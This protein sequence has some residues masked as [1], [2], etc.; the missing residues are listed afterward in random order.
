MAPLLMGLSALGLIILITG[1]AMA[2]RRKEGKP[3]LPAAFG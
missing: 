2:T 1:I 3:Q